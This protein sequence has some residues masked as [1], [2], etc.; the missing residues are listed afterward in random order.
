MNEN[1]V[2]LYLQQLREKLEF[3]SDVDDVINALNWVLSLAGVQS[4]THSPL[5]QTTANV[6]RRS[7]ARL[8]QKKTLVSVGILSEIVEDAE[9]YPCLSSDIWLT[10]VCLLAFSG[11]MWFDELIQLWPINITVTDEM[12]AVKI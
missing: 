10:T 1:C 7:L 9:T 12:M 5:V 3:K 4:P 11:F 2:T 8:V 6:L